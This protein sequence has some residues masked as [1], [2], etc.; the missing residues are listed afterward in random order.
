MPHLI[1][2]TLWTGG[3]RHYGSG[4]LLIGEH[5]ELPDFDNQ[6]DQDAIKVVSDGN[7]CAYLKRVNAKVVSMLIRMGLTGRWLLKP[8]AVPETKEYKV[9]HDNDVISVV[10]VN[11]VRP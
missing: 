6:S 3:M 9:G 7:T 1:I 2:R 10:S 5:Y 11:T 8:K 4:Q